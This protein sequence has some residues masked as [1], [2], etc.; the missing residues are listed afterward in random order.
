MSAVVQVVVQQSAISHADNEH[1]TALG[2]DPAVEV[3]ERG[4]GVGEHLL[5][6]SHPVKVVVTV[7]NI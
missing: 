1:V 5:R 7:A 4:H 3:L 2:Q 6:C